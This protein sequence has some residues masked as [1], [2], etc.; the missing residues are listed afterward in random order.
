M[1]NVQIPEELFYD[2]CR[3]HL[4]S[5]YAE[6]AD[7]EEIERN[8]IE[9]LTKKMQAIIRHELYSTYKD[10]TMSE[11]ERQRARKEYL[12]SIGLRDDFRWETLDLPV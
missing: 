4:T 11:Q 6:T 2:L 9:G 1:K 5:S 10:K 7:P 12:N 3:Y 8:I